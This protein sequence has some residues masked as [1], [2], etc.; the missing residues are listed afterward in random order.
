MAEIK[1]HE[2]PQFLKQRA[3]SY[4]I[5]LVYGPD[6]GL[7][8]ERAG[9]LAALSGI[10]TDDPFSFLRI[11]AGTLASDP[12]KLYDEASSSGLFGGGK[13]IWIKGA[14]ADKALADA[15]STLDRKSVV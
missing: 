6:R 15:I 1:A 13:L 14:G 12:G 4:R 8:S 5:F 2:F 9:E 11:D 7:V 3:R 10:P